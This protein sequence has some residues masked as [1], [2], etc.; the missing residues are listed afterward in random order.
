MDP[1]V[2]AV[3]PLDNYRLEIEFENGEQRVFDVK[4]YLDRGIFVRLKNRA[5]FRA[6]RVVAGSVE[7]PGGLD[8]CYE[9]LYAASEPVSVSERAELA[10]G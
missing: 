1:F 3:R 7:W 6:V 4:P 10:S 9:T 2:R 5:L 8:L